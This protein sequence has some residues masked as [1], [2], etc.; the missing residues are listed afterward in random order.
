LNLLNLICE[1]KVNK[2]TREF[3]IRETR[4]SQTSIFEAYSKHKMGVQFKRLSS[5]LDEHPG[6]QR[7]WIFE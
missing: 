5:I 4:L 7:S 2:A 1:K 6:F 3:S